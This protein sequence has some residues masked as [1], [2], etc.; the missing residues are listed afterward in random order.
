MRQVNVPLGTRRYSIHVG[1]QL[2]PQL[3]T[4]CLKLKLGARCAV[5]SDTNVARLH[6]A[7]ALA[8]L[9]A[10]GFSPVLI[11]LPAGEQAKS[12]A[13]AQRCYRALAAHRLERGSFI[14]ALGGG[15]V[16][17]LAGFVAATYLRGMDFVQVPTTLLAQVDSSVG[18]KVGVN[19][20]EGKNL[21]GAFHQP[22]GVFC[23][24]DTLQTLPA[25]EYRAG[26][27]EVI[28]YGIIADAALFA[29]LERDMD[30]L[31]Q[32]HPATLETVVARCCAIKAGVVA[33]DEREG[34]LRA[35]LNFGHTIGHGLEAISGYGKYLHGEA[36]S[37]GQVAAARLSQSLAGLPEREVMRIETLFARAGLPTK[38]K[39]GAAQERRLLNAMKLDKKVSGGEIHFVLAPRMGRA[40]CGHRV[41]E[42]T[43]R[44]ALNGEA[45]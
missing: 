24:L 34:G 4:R 40:T 7:A 3:G 45:A 11:P 10:A 27:A 19:L 28:K 18:G 32:K 36:I 22:R 38:V 1:Q 9:R 12:L 16:G 29:R 43:V 31:L 35:I 42:P 21:V 8:S 25:R 13:H 41:P 20:P 30:Q 5:I 33:R 37:I 23:D 39:L 17:D 26:L 44:A 14:V 6:G 15:V 2:L